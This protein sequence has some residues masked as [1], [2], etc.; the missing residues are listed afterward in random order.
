MAAP[1]FK[2]LF[3]IQCDASDLGLGFVLSQESDEGKKV[4]IAFAG[5]T[6]TNAER[7]YTVTEKE[8]LAVLFAVDK[9][10]PYVEDIK[11]KLVADHYSLLWLH[12]LKS[13]SGRL[14]RWAVKLQQFD[15]Y[16]E[17]RKGASNVMPD[18]LSL[19]FVCCTL[20]RKII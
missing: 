9:F 10:R 15:F 3:N 13:P 4:V 11:F 1:N 19:K 14:A 12:N 2:K 6:L 20:T 18:T 5:R 8:L 7:K 17:H 16:L